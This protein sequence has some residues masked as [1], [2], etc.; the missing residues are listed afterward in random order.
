MT[1]EEAKK[2]YLD[3][4]PVWHNGIEYPYILAR[5]IQR[6]KDGKHIML[7][8]LMDKCSHSITVARVERVSLEPPKPNGK[9]GEQE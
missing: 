1:N 6:D 7:L 3:M 5:K 8:E 9:D 2:A 4:T